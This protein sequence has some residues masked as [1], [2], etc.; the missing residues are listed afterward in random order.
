M[1][2]LL[3]LSDSALPLGSFAFSSGLES[4][5]AHLTH[6]HR[7]RPSF[8]A[9]LPHCFPSPLPSSLPCL[10]P[11]IASLPSLP[12]FLHYL[13]SFLNCLFPSTIFFPSLPCLLSFTVLRPLPSKSLTSRASPHKFTSI[14]ALHSHL[15]SS[16]INGTFGT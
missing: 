16:S 7:V 12:P 10:L 15:V 13:P 8:T 11:F 5:Q 2:F 6:L 1:H 9:F 14:P 4:Y 3:L